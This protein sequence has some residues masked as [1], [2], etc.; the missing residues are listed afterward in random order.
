MFMGCSTEKRKKQGPSDQTSCSRRPPSRAQAQTSTCTRPHNHGPYSILERV[1]WSHHLRDGSVPHGD[2]RAPATRRPGGNRRPV[3]PLR[4]PAARPSSPELES[5]SKT[6]SSSRLRPPDNQGGNRRPVSPR[7]R[8]AASSR[9]RL[10][11]TRPTLRVSP[12]E[13]LPSQHDKSFS[14]KDESQ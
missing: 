12:W 6:G 7:G 3:S 10:S 8:P 9:H 4:R 5:H 13:D 2:H 1:A 14:L 11:P